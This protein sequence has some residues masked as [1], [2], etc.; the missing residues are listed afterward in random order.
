MKDFEKKL[1]TKKS[2]DISKWYTE[3]IQLA[4]V[5]DYGPVRGTMV[6]MP[7]GFAIWENIRKEFDKAVERLGAENAY[8]PLFIPMRLLQKEKT[9]IKGF[10]PELAVVT[11]GGGEELKEPL[12]VRPTSETVMYETYSKWISSWR[13]LPLAINQWNN[14]VRWEKRT[15]FFLRT[16][17][18]L[19]QEGHTAHATGLEA[20]E[21]TLSALSEYE[22][23]YRE[24][25]AIEPLVGEKSES[26]KFAGADRTYAT[27]LLM[28]NGKA[29]QG[30]T[31]HNLGTNFS[32]TFDISFQDEDGKSQFV[33]QTSWGLST[34]SIG[35][36]I[37]VHGDDNGLKIPPRLAPIKA[38][39]IPVLGKKD[40]KILA[41]CLKVK[42]EIEGKESIFPGKVEVLSDS[43][44]SY[45]W[46][47]NESEMKGV[48]LK[49]TIGG[50]EV[51][52]KTATVSFRMEGMQP[53][54]V[55][56][57][58]IASII[59][60]MLNQVQEAMYKKSKEFLE[61]SIFEVDS[62]DEFKKIMQTKRGLIKAF[63]C[64]GSNCET[65]MKEE[66]KA[67]TR[68]K[69]LN[70]KQ[71]KGRCI[72]CGKEAKFRWFFAQAY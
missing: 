41:Y 61:N 8:F 20:Q 55:R 60:E 44:K 47:V 52:E 29:L 32:K 43:E 40:E 35:G 15:Y 39:I 30:A 7:Y 11:H 17:E 58:D 5:A 12:A 26:E 67:T 31:S 45:G 13:D 34:R 36:L 4:K 50:R 21:M 65:K 33:S 71:E 37:L 18:F 70:A 28:P 62:Y 64:E 14:V 66:T 53:R 24:V 27:E 57:S 46:R 3:V 42:E 59:E 2:K 9:H 54:L 10:A 51:D 56:F 1:L 25:Y 72:Y 23:I 63:W 68:V 19:W 48:P 49:I 6:I 38:S 22:K 16:L 69:P